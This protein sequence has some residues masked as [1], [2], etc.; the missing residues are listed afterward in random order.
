MMKNY[1]L[2]IALVLF[3]NLFSTECIA[4]GEVELVF[5]SAVEVSPRPEVSIYDIVEAKNLD[6]DMANELKKIVIKDSSLNVLSKTELAKILRTIKARFVLPND[7]KIIRSQSV[8][9]RMEVE[10]KIK[11]KIYANCSDCEVQVQIS[12]VPNTMANDWTLDLN[13]DLTKSTLMVPIFSVKNSENRGWIVAEIKKYQ[14]VP[15]LNKSVKIGEI[16]TEDMLTLEKREVSNRRD[17]VLKIE[18]V[19]GM[20]VTRFLNAGQI[21]QYT[22]LKKEQ[23]LKKGQMV[24]AMVGGA[25]FEVAISA[26]VQEA[27]AI[28][29]IVKVKNLDSQ[30]VFAAKIVDRGIVR[31]E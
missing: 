24:R 6:D 26:E 27:G 14:N 13:I 29:E 3:S 25:D 17:T 9:S 1:R 15:V 5:S 10:R 21:I 16:L 30:K 23:V 19:V 20:Q 28:G 11:N 8:I 31:I 2:V 7:M 4:L 22:D 18:S 12:S